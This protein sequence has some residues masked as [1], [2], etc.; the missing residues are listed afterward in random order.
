MAI[1][2]VLRGWLILGPHREIDADEAVVG[3]MALQVPRELPVFFW[4][5][6]YLGSLEALVAAGMFA[7]FGPSGAVLKAV[8]A[9]FSLLFVALVYLT[10]RH[11]FGTGP[12][13]LSAAYLAVPPSFLA[14]WSVKARGGYAE[15]LATG[16]LFLFL[17]QMVA[18]RPGRGARLAALGGLVGGLALWIHPLALV[19]LLVGVVY[20]GLSLRGRLAPATLAMGAGGFVV[21]A[22]PV[23]A[24]NVVEEFASVR[25]ATVDGIG[26]GSAL[27]N[28]WGLARYGAPVLAGL[29]EGTPSKVL[30]DEDW[31]HRPGSS[32]VVMGLLMLLVGF[33]ASRYLGSLQSLVRGSPSPRRR[34]A[35]FLLLLLAI[36]PFVAVSRFAEL[37]AEPRYALPVYGS[38]PLFAALAWQVRARSRRGFSILIAVVLTVNVGSLLT[39]DPRMALPVSAGAS[40]ERNRGELIEYLLA[41]NLTRVYTDYWIA[42]PLAFESDERIVPAVRSGGFDRRHAYAHQVSVAQEPAF[43]FPTDAPGDVQF[44][45]DLAALGGSA[46][47]VELSVYRVYT[48]V[49]PLEAL[50]RSGALTVSG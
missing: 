6:H 50:R 11:S 38:I 30:L 36:P 29:A 43:V 40:N 26:S 1:G 10:G 23:L 19:Y 20:V 28:L 49:R 39:G 44:R 9:A 22:S 16:Q 32:F 31:P 21:G 48:N 42:Y 46:D 34:G 27:L 18:E 35:L 41:H 8:P 15:L 37:W 45:L 47:V 2:A 3:L 17:C 14:V 25:Y 12:A 5:Q 33:V 13:L 4:E 7:I 24:Y